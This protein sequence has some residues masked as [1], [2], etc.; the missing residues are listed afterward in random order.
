VL[1]GGAAALGAGLFQACATRRPDGLVTAAEP[2]RFARVRVSPQRV[3]RT[4]VGL[5]PFRPSVE[6]R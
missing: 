6:M 2:R 3:I 1:A 4:V 5:R